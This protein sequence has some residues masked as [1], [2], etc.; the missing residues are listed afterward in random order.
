MEIPIHIII[1]KSYIKEGKFEIQYRKTGEKKYIKPEGLEG[2][3]ENEKL[4]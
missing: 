4:S 1:G 2:I 3:L